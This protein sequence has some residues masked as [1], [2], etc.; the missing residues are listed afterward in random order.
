[1]HIYIYIYIYIYEQCKVIYTYVRTY[2]HTYIH[3]Y[4]H[5]CIHTY[6]HTYIPWGATPCSHRPSELCLLHGQA[7]RPDWKKKENVEK[8]MCWLHG[9][10]WRPDWRGK[11]K[12][13]NS[14][15]HGMEAKMKKRKIIV[16][17]TRGQAWRPGCK[18][19]L[20]N[21]DPLYTLYI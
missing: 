11:E 3:T 1:M 13:N 2:I 16:L 9:Q 10:A 7:W 5:A 19:F 20:K 8:E 14:W 17:V 4:M 21:S 18:K 15:L 6:I 12:S